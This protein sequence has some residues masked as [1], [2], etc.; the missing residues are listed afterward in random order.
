MMSSS[1]NRNG[2]VQ[3]SEAVTILKTYEA[4]KAVLTIAV[5]R[6]QRRI[7]G[8]FPYTSAPT[9]NK[10]LV[11]SLHKILKPSSKKSENPICSQK[12]TTES[13]FHFWVFPPNIEKQLHF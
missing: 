8:L 10:N 13:I 3:V 7:R 6:H 4:Q 5:P 9:E 2:K 12:I 1:L 11:K